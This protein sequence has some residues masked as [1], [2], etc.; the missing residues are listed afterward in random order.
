MPIENPLATTIDELNPAWPTGSDPV[1]QGD[2]HIRQIKQAL[3]NSFPGLTTQF[4]SGTILGGTGDFT[5]NKATAGGYEITFTKAASSDYDQ[6]FTANAVGLVGF[7]NAAVC[8]V[9]PIS[10]SRCDVQ[11]TELS[12]DNYVDQRFT[13]IRTAK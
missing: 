7:A 9:V 5:V 11:I 3:L 6:S 4:T 2:D 10:P 12:N 8:N 1:S 13:F